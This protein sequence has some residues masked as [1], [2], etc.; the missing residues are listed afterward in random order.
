MDRVQVVL[1]AIIVALLA[2]GVVALIKGWLPLS[3]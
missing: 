1:I 2:L 3:P